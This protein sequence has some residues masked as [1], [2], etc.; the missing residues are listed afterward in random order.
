MKVYR[1]NET[2]KAQIRSFVRQHGRQNVIDT[3][4]SDSLSG[5]T[6]RDQWYSEAES[7]MERGEC[8]IEM[9]MQYSADRNPHTLRLSDDMF[10]AEEI[11]D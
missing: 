2:G 3:F 9:G 1:I 10:D 4:W 6:A 5:R 11:Q 8:S 7:A